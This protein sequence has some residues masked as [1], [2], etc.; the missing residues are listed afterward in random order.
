MTRFVLGL[1]GLVLLGTGPLLGQAPQ[2]LPPG[3]AEPTPRAGA[4]W[5]APPHLITGTATAAPCD[6]G[7]VP[8]KKVCVPEPYLKETRRVTYSSGC[9][10][11]CLCF[12]VGLFHCGECQ[13]RCEHAIPTRYL[14]KKVTY[15]KQPAV[16]CVPQDV[17]A[18]ATGGCAAAP[19]CESTLLMPAPAG[20]PAAMAPPRNPNDPGPVPPR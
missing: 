15:C 3:P 8:T 16:K 19:A 10:T 11:R 18:G 6:C 5:T 9:D 14:I 7:P 12:F 1:M 17:P 20:A 13:G 2:T 4:E